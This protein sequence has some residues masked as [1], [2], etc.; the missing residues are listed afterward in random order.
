MYNQTT[1]KQQSLT[2]SLLISFTNKTKQ[3]QVF[4]NHIKQK[5]FKTEFQ[6]KIGLLSVKWTY[7]SNRNLPS[8]FEFIF[9]KL[10]LSI[11]IFISQTKQTSSISLK[12]ILI[13]SIYTIKNYKHQFNSPFII[14]S[15]SK[16]TVSFFPTFQFN[17]FKHKKQINS[18]PIVTNNHSQTKLTH[19]H[20]S[21]RNSKNKI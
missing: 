2:K 15:T 20:H 8:T 11:S 16:I 7:S 13:L 21:N 3:L 18:A 1:H 14:G 19:H 12:I 4:S 9:K 6:F 10:N 5:L 17:T